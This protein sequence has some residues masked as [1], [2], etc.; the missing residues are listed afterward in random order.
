MK[1]LKG[2]TKATGF[3]TKAILLI[4]LA[5]ITCTCS[6]VR[7]TLAPPS[8]EKL[9]DYS[10]SSGKHVKLINDVMV[11]AI[12][13][14]DALVLV[15]WHRQKPLTWLQYHPTHG[16]GYCPNLELM[17]KRSQYSSRFASQWSSKAPSVLCA[18][19]TELPGADRATKGDSTS[20]TC[21]AKLRTTSLCT[22]TTRK[23]SKSKMRRAR[24]RRP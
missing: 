19:T 3:T 12:S 23:A 1:N 17:L 6:G 9:I 13:K 7:L 8:L 11:C 24:P 4:L 2:E 15:S 5:L 16:S 20:L 18:S 22:P 14:T 10:S 21:R